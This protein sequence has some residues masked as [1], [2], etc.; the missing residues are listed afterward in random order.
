MKKKHRRVYNLLVSILKYID[1]DYL[2]YD[3]LWDKTNFETNE[4]NINEPNE[5]RHLIEKTIAVA[6]ETKSKT[7]QKFTLDMLTLFLNDPFDF[8]EAFDIIS[9]PYEIKSEN[10]IIFIKETLLQLETHYNKQP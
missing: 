1:D 7:E 9:T 4:L 6:F 5:M 8:T 2:D 10:Q 3:K